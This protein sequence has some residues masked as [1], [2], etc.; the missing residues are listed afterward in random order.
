VALL[1]RPSGRA[2]NGLRLRKSVK[3]EPSSLIEIRNGSTGRWEPL[4]TVNGRYGTTD[5]IH[6]ILPENEEGVCRLV[7]PDT[8]EQMATARKPD[9]ASVAE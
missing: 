1:A 4:D 3:N 9:A 6:L 5:D 8:E 2:E 7:D